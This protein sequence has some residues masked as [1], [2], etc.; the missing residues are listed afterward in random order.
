MTEKVNRRPLRAAEPILRLRTVSMDGARVLCAR[1]R[2]ARRGGLSMM[3]RIQLLWNCFSVGDG[4][5]FPR[6]APN[7]FSTQMGTAKL[8][9]TSA[10]ETVVQGFR[11]ATVAESLAGSVLG[12]AGRSATKALGGFALAKLVYD[13]A[14]FA[15]GGLY[16]I[17]NS[18][19]E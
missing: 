11:S 17:F 18:S 13:T 19:D 1:L 7:P 12:A 8:A 16:A 14:S 2:M 4:V 3:S 5:P 15:I 6:P 10:G 9:E